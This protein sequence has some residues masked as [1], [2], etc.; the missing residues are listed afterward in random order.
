MTQRSSNVAHTPPVIADVA[1]RLR[2]SYPPTRHHNKR[3]V[4]WEL[5]FIM[6]SARTAEALYLDTYRQLRARYPTRKKL[7][8][9][10]PSAVARTIRKGGL[11]VKK[12][13]QLVAIARAYPAAL[14]RGLRQLDDAELE[15]ALTSLPGVGPK[16]ARC[17]AMYALDRRVFP[18]DV[19]ALRVLRRLGYTTARRVTPRVADDLQALVP[20]RIRAS[21]HISLLSHGRAMCTEREPLCHLCPLADVCGWSGA[22]PP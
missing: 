11:S 18:V 4:F 6:L 16:T 5:A 1:R 12:A 15:V 21:L 7:A 20:P 14:T 3:Q 22:S 19:H 10:R 13:A 8:G 2:R 17:V 9:A